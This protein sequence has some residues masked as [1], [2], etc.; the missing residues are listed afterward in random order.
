[1]FVLL[2]AYALVL[3]WVSCQCISLSAAATFV[4]NV[5]FP[6]QYSVLP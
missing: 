3:I 5:A 1:M 2:L 6:K 4:D